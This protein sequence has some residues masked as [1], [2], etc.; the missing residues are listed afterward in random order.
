MENNA[1][2]YIVDD[3][4]AI[5]RALTELVEIIDLKAKSYT[6]GDEFLDAFEPDGPAC[7]VL[8]VRM[9]GISGLELQ[10]ALADRGSSLPTIVISG[11]SDV[12]M[13][14]DAMKAGA[15]EFLEKPFRTQELCD[16]IQKAIRIDSDAWCKRR[17]REES[18]RRI[19]SLT[20]AEKDV[21]D[22]VAAGKTNRAIAEELDLSI[23]TV[24]DR[25]ARMMKK[26]CLQTRAELL[27]LAAA[28]T[29]GV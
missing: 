9:P 20:P 6:S 10:R 2:V 11:H 14:V 25:R 28:E 26:L 4:P 18:A 7:L 3:D 24:E 19:G 12:R 16:N 15:T 22:L 21:F 5:I 29:Q 1:T 8:D 13:A 23:R 27:E 17:S